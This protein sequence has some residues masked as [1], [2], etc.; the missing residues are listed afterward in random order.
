MTNHREPEI[1]NSNPAAASKNQ[2][3][4]DFLTLSVKQYQSQII[5]SQ[6]FNDSKASQIALRDVTLLLTYIYKHGQD[7]EG[8]DLPLEDIFKEII[9]ILIKYYILYHGISYSLILINFN[10]Y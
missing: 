4:L 7:I 2:K 3:N 8:I 10:V 9:G 1:L 6:E 5:E